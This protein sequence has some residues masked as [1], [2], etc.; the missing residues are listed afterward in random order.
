MKL[1]GFNFNKIS[2]EKLSSSPKAEELKVSTNINIIDITS[3][4]ADLIKTKDEL[5]S[6]KFDYT[7]N[8][9]PDFAKLEFSGDILVEVEPRLIKDV[10]KDWKTKDIPEEFKIFIFNLILI[11]A[12]LKGLELEEDTNIPF[13]MPFPSIPLKDKDKKFKE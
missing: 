9:E 3:I 7:I 6:V 1:L 10:L 11:K 4:K 8:Y 5:V 2:I 13:H 12:S